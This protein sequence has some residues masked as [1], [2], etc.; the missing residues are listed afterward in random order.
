MS[1]DE[2]GSSSST[3]GAAT[4]G[5]GAEVHALTSENM[6]TYGSGPGGRIGPCAGFSD[7]ELLPL[8]SMTSTVPSDA[9]IPMAGSKTEARDRPAE[10]MMSN[11]SEVLREKVNDE[12]DQ[13]EAIRQE[14]VAQGF[15]DWAE[16]EVAG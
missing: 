15:M 11:D 3:E 6:R 12:A 2:G 14:L 5:G 13:T 16:D 9:S 4:S 8:V 7:E 1:S 10:N